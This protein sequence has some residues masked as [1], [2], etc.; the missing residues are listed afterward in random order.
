[1]DIM[2]F[3]MQ[4]ELDGKAHYEKLASQTDHSGLKTI[5]L[6]LAQDEQKHYQIIQKMKEGMAGTMQE[7]AVLEEAQNVFTVIAA[8]KKVV[9]GLKDSAEGYLY[10]M[11]IEA[12]S[13]KLYEDAATKVA[14]PEQAQLL[15]KIAN[16]EK[17]HYNIM[18]NLYYFVLEPSYY[19]AWREF[20]N[21][22]EL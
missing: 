21:L 6:G 4:M 10:A 8:D 20:S 17:K 3:A 2:A 19:L 9:D 15:L 13:V 11:K 14:D 16:E 18:D 5:F 12:D 22:R 7:T 1:M